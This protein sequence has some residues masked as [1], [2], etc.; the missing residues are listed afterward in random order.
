[1]ASKDELA[2]AVAEKRGCSISEASSFIG[3][4]IDVFQA[5]LKTE[6]VHLVG[7]GSWKRVTRKARQGCN[8]RTG[9]SIM[10]PAKTVVKF[11]AS[12]GLTAQ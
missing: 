12:K 3:T 2:R 4:L 6:D 1:M 9:E 10:I 7:L 5:T 8:P 11:K